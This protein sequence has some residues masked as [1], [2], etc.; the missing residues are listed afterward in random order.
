METKQKRQGAKACAFYPSANQSCG[1]IK[2]GSVK[3]CTFVLFSL[4]EKPP[5][6]IISAIKYKYSTV[7]TFNYALCHSFAKHYFPLSLI[8]V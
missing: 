2:N 6:E 8:F 4:D 7:S 1:K 3:L 5:P